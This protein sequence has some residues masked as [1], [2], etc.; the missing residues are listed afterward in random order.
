M[1]S[2][3]M[4]NRGSVKRDLEKV[5]KLQRA[6]GFKA[7]WQTAKGAEKEL[8]AELR[9]GALGMDPLSGIGQWRIKGGKLKRRG[10]GGPLA[11]LAKAVSAHVDR[12]KSRGSTY[13]ADI[14][15]VKTGGRHGHLGMVLG[16]RHQAG[17]TIKATRGLRRF[18][19]RIGAAIKEKSPRSKLARY[20]FLKQSTSRLS[21][22]A[23]P[24]IDPF[25][26]KNAERLGRQAVGN[27]RT[28]MR[29]A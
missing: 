4:T 2:L 29:G 15:F 19:A 14:G 16:K 27:Y 17:F 12:G 24:I 22:P 5:S 23:R 9:A 25:W 7:V 10:R 11:P 8:K 28:L 3:K 26:A 6:M 20:F 1:I 21:V 13:I 18:F